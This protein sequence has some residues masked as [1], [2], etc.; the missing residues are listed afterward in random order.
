MGL[1]LQKVLAAM[2]RRLLC[3]DGLHELIRLS[4]EQIL[5]PFTSI[6][7]L[8]LLVKEHNRL[9]DEEKKKKPATANG[10]KGG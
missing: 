5:S 4:N 7:V 6:I 8:D 2:I 3:Q 9:L 1:S 10:C